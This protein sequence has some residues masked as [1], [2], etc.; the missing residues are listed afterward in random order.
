MFDILAMLHNHYPYL[1]PKYFNH[2]QTK[3]EPTK[4]LLPIFPLASLVPGTATCFL[5]PSI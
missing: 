1:I 5:F 2:A 4:Q 3:L